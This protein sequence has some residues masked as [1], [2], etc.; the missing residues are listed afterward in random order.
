MEALPF[1]SFFR[2]ACVRSAEEILYHKPGCLNY[3]GGCNPWAQFLCISRLRLFSH[4]PV[5]PESKEVDVPRMSH[6]LNVPMRD[7]QDSKAS[8]IS[9]LPGLS[10]PLGPSFPPH[11]RT[12]T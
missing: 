3:T 9:R 5:H 10:A 7:P 11:R 4:I 8:T 2:W 1:I 12:R 6:Q